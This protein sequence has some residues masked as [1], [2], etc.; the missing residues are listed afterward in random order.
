VIPPRGDIA[1]VARRC[2]P[3]PAAVACIV[4]AG[5]ALAAGLHI[6]AATDMRPRIV[7]LAPHLTELVFAA[8]GGDRLVGTVEYSDFPEAAR[9]IPRVGDAWRVDIERLLALKPDIVLT[10][11]SGTPPDIVSRLDALKLRRLDIPTYR[12]ADVP[13]ALLTL[14]KL[15]GTESIARAAADSFS[16]QIESLRREYAHA[17]PVTVFIQLDD[18]PLFTVNAHH[19]ISEIVEL[20]GGRNVFA[21]LPQLAPPVGIEAVIAADPQVILST[22]DTIPDPAS[23]WQQWSRL[24]AV[25]HRTIY[26]IHA[27]TVARSTPRLVQGTRETCED[28][29]DARR[30]LGG[31]G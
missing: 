4:A 10:W 5:L 25:R 29:A 16:S 18:Q 27:D 23:Q 14:G 21:N 19:M 2:R 22:D 28:L 24:T 20:C 3:L 30:R 17:P 31:A 13:A 8:G 12:L 9:A 6:A 7:S 1:V 26:G 11:A 15:T